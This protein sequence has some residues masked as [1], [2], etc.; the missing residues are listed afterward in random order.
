MHRSLQDLPVGKQVQNGACGRHPVLFLSCFKRVPP[1]LWRGVTRR[2]P[3][4]PEIKLPYPDSGYELV[5]EPPVRGFSLANTTGRYYTCRRPLL[6]LNFLSL[7]PRQ[8]ISTG[9][10]SN[11][12]ARRKKKEGEA[13]FTGNFLSPLSCCRYSLTLLLF[14]CRHFLTL[15][16]R[17]CLQKNVW[18][19]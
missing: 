11:R 8:E 17:F 15:P 7:S 14:F 1:Q 3:T 16:V 9:L 19:E 12:N 5:Y 18:K 13:E 4:P 6:C 10:C 2:H